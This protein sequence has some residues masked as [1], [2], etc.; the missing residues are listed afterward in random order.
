MKTGK[1]PG[2][3]GIPPEAIKYAVEV[4]PGWI[5]SVFNDLLR[6]R[7]FHDMWKGSV[8][9]LTLWEILC[10]GRLRL[11]LTKG[12]ISIGYADDFTIV[13]IAENVEE[14]TFRVNESVR[15]V[16]PCME[17]AGVDVTAVIL[18]SAAATPL[19]AG[20]EWSRKE[21]DSPCVYTPPW[22]R[23]YP[24]GVAM[25]QQDNAPSH[26]SMVVGWGLEEH[27]SNF[28][29]ID[30]PSPDLNPIE[31]D[32]VD[33]GVRSMNATATIQDQLWVAVQ[34]ACDGPNFRGHSPYDMRATRRQV[35]RTCSLLRT[36]GHVGGASFTMVGRS[37][38][39]AY[40]V[41]IGPPSHDPRHR[42]YQCCARAI[43]GQIKV[44]TD[45]RL[46]INAYL[47]I[48]YAAP[49]VGE[50][51]FAPPQIHSGWNRSYFAGSYKSACPQLQD[52]ITRSSIALQDED[53]LY[54]NVWT[55]ELQM[56]YRN[57]PVV[58]FLEGEGFISG[59][60]ARFPG[61][62]LA[63]EGLVVVT[64]NYRLN[65]FG[66]LC[67][68][69]SLVRGN[70]GLLDQYFALQWVQQNI[71]SFRGDPRSVT[72]M[73]HSA[74]A[75]SV[76]FHLAS[77]RT[78]G[79]FHRAILMSGSVTSPWTRAQHSSNASMDIVRSLGCL[80]SSTEA[81]LQCLRGK[82]VAEI[83]RAFE[84]QY[85]NGNWSD[86]VLPVLDTFLPENE[87]YLP[88][89]PEEVLDSGS[90]QAMPILTGITTAEGAVTL[91]QWGDLVR[92]GY[93]HLRQ[94]LETSAIPHIMERYG[95]NKEKRNEIREI[96]K[97]QYLERAREGD[98]GALLT[99]ILELYSDAQFR[100]PH[101]R[102]LQLLLRSPEPLY[103]YR[104]EQTGGPDIYG[105][106]INISGAAHGSE[107]LYLLG[108]TMMMQTV[109]RRLTAPED[110]LGK[111]MKRMW[112]DFILQGN[113]SP[114]SY[115]Y[116]LGWKHYTG[117]ENEWYILSD[118]IPRQG[119]SQPKSTTA[120]SS[121]WNDLLPRI[122]ALEK[123]EDSSKTEESS[124]SP[125]GP[126][127][128]QPDSSQPFRSA[129][130]TL[131]GFVAILLILLIVCLVLLKKRTKE[132]ERDLF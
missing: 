120:A 102:Q 119:Y 109:G 5:L 68:N 10:D 115:G 47:G 75:T 121:F 41:R 111:T 125:V 59:S 103:V 81:V 116:G 85:N 61:Q 100:A 48:P 12:T 44:Y 99:Q 93:S 58:V 34:D 11:Q 28:T 19:V 108:P 36:S 86:L 33:A 15:R 122:E 70:L 20:S 23:E 57:M 132:R 66:F 90:Y 107:F 8:L 126:P 67:L 69:D 106:T 17:A 63:A 29:K 40:L 26:R 131:I 31:W 98:T 25:F 38:S 54:L 35:F 130:Y 94:F 6:K 71:A 30:W 2:E 9:G 113:P 114:S 7:E 22:L 43:L 78:G 24:D 77:P 128:E 101:A 82:S 42:L 49:P 52:V 4:A 62:D 124:P 13:V 129:M 45:G 95:F 76:L 80:G 118:T 14:L 91:Y 73:G 89:D 50:L 117:D 37:E 32:A 110:R 123:E 97:W 112:R 104:F 83:L 60:A 51:R 65:V 16:N 72:L 53:C 105:S 1:A 92:Q 46:P 96:I 87:Q 127:M 56:N 55:P 88:R 39:V 21:T 74:G 18:T 3:H 79:T 27:S 64:V 84:S